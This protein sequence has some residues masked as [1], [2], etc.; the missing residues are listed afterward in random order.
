MLTCF[1]RLQT[2]WNSAVRTGSRK[3][4]IWQSSDLV[5]WSSASVVEVENE[6]AGMVWAPS[7]VWNGASFDVF[8]ASRFY[9]ADDTAH[10]GNAGFDIIRTAST[11]DF[12]TFSSPK[13]YIEPTGAYAINLID[14]EFQKTPTGWVRFLK[15]EGAVSGIDSICSLCFVA[16]SP[17]I[18]TQ[19]KV[20]K[21][22]SSSPTV[23]GN[24]WTRVGQWVIDQVRE[25]PA[26]FAD[27]VEAGKYHLWLDNYSGNG[28]YEPYIVS[29]WR[30]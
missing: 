2:D 13:N 8:W 15:D 19:L 1:T 20:F 22:V 14:Q 3:L 25:G 12:K 9:A 4:I 27:N 16:H 24:D 23:F 10:T 30:C 6:Q 7:A 18:T 5:T 26:S 29:S 11:T 21:E 17:Y 28:S